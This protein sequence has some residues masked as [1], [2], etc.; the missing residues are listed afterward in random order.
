[1]LRRVEI[2]IVI[3]SCYDLIKFFLNVFPE[4]KIKG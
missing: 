3:K 2:K 4:K 1:M